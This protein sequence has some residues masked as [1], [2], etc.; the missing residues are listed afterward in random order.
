[1][2]LVDKP[3]V[4]GNP[5]TPAIL[6]VLW[7]QDSATAN[8]WGGWPQKILI[9]CKLCSL[10]AH[11]GHLCKIICYSCDAAYATSQ[12]PWKS[13][14]FMENHYLKNVQIPTY[15]R[16]NSTWIDMSQNVS[17]FSRLH[18]ILYCFCRHHAIFYIAFIFT[19]Y[20]IV[21]HKITASEGDQC[22]ETWWI[23]GGEW[24]NRNRT[25][26]NATSLCVAVL[27]G[28][29][30]ICETTVLMGCAGHFDSCPIKN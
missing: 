5:L 27:N 30:V 4:T 8:L 1:M 29:C 12:N 15:F 22:K 2:K 6:K 20:H 17:Y 11:K 19:C 9:F 21:L 10:P 24:N 23:Q 7:V 18:H 26:S 28:S 16:H 14:I 25:M 13:I 3:T